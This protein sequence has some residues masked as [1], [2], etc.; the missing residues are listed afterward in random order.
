[1]SFIIN[2]APLFFCCC[3]LVSASLLSSFNR[4]LGGYTPSLSTS[5][6]CLSLIVGT[7]V[8]LQIV[9]RFLM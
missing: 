7:I 6:V 4:N 2:L 9:L 3:L 8:I 1:M 5:S